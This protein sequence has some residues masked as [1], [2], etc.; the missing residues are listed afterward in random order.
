MKFHA[1]VSGTVGTRAE[2]EQG[3]AGKR[4]AL[5]QHLRDKEYVTVCDQAGFGHPEHHL[6]IEGM[7]VP[8]C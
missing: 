4:P 1:I 6:Q 8:G 5:Y 2:L 7:E 3:M